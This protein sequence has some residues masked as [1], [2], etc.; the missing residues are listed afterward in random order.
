MKFISQPAQNQH[1]N[2]DNVED[3]MMFRKAFDFENLDREKVQKDLKEAFEKVQDKTQEN[4]IKV[5]TDFTFKTITSYYKPE[6]APGWAARMIF[7]VDGVGDYSIIIKNDKAEYIKGLIDNPTCNVFTDVGTL[8]TQLCIIRLED[9][10]EDDELTDDDLEMVAGG[11]GGG[12]GAE[13]SGPAV[14][15]QDYTGVGG[16]VAAACGGAACG[17]AVCA[18]DACGGAACGAA[19]CELA[20]CGGAACPADACAGA[21][22]GVAVGVGGCLGNACGVDVQ[23]AGDIGPCAVNVCPGVPGI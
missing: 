14:C 3:L 17:G 5:Q 23:G 1:F 10:R 20:A 9:V 22:C 4:L 11:K 12:C 2:S 18:Y 16:C 19:G 13:A 21:A 6:A 15:G 7:H 8:A